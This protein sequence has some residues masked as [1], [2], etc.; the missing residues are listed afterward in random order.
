MD[1]IKRC[2]QCYEEFE[3]SGNFHDNPKKNVRFCSMDCLY[4]FIDWEAM[5]KVE[6]AK[7]KRKLG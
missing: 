5:D 1:K 3:G 6:D 2:S 4:E 7:L